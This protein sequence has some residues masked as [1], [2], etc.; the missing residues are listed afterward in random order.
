MHMSLH[1]W[2]GFKISGTKSETCS[3]VTNNALWFSGL[4]VKTVIANVVN[5]NFGNDKN[6]FKYD[7]IYVKKYQKSV[8]RG[9]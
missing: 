8:K 1:G 4:M 9:Q 2:K 5:D 3:G 6:W 7:F